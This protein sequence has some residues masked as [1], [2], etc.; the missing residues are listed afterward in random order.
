MA[1]PA[2]RENDKSQKPTA[3]DVNWVRAQFPALKQT[4]NGQPAAFLDAPAG[5]QVPQRVIDAVREYYEQSTR[6]PAAH[7]PPAAAPT[8]SSPPHAPPWPICSIARPT[9]SSSAP[10]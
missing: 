5:T 9:N 8:R 6:T 1:P 3:L 2:F 7:S 10:T 4:V